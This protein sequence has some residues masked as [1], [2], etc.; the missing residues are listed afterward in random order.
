[1]AD[2]RLYFFKDKTTGKKRNTGIIAKSVS[3]AK[4]KLKRP[5]SQKAV[6]Y[7]SRKM[8]P[9]EKKTADRGDWVTGGPNK[10]ERRAKKTG[11]RGYGPSKAASRKAHRRR[12]GLPTM[13]SEQEAKRNKKNN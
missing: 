6:L 12:S 1:M 2:Y 5:S 4:S 8:T 10:G 3:T 9:A 11:S 13:L 7:A